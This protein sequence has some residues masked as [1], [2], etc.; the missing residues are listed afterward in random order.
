[1]VRVQVGEHHPNGADLGAVS[2]FPGVDLVPGMT[3]LPDE[4]DPDLEPIRVTENVISAWRWDAWLEAAE[5]ID[6]STTSV[7]RIV[8]HLDD[9]SLL[10]L[11]VHGSALVP[12]PSTRIAAERRDAALALVANEYDL[13]R[14]RD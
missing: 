8:D 12:G 5:R 10:R 13:S 7:P 11:L 4:I 9:E 1:M 3:K 2:W 14:S 6:R